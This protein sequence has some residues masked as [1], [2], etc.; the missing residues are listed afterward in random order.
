MRRFIAATTMMVMLLS[1]SSAL[2]DPH[3]GFVDLTL[4]GAG[5]DTVTAQY[6]P[7]VTENG[8][9][10]GPY[11][12]KLAA[13]STP[14][15]SPPTGQVSG[16]QP[17]QTSDLGTGASRLGFCISLQ[18][19]ISQNVLYKDFYVETIADAL[20]TVKAQNVTSLLY[21]Y[22]GAPGFGTLPPTAG[23]NKYQDALTMAIWE[24]LT[25]TSVTTP[26]GVTTGNVQFSNPSSGNA[27]SALAIADGWLAALPT[28]TGPQRAT[29]TSN[30][31]IYGLVDGNVQA[32]SIFI[33]LPGASVPEPGRVV[34]LAGM[35]LLG[36]PLGF[37][38][39]RRRYRH[40]AGAR[41]AT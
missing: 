24:V 18:N 41:R 33:S 10:L 32:Q 12:Y 1:A 13:A 15:P 4:T 29:I 37:I 34:G 40:S 20:G 38:S 2:A 26:F 35:G 19:S 31:G 6:P 14:L 3:L 21:L 7:S 39:L 16:M 17:V 9:L 30:T 11:A 36:L 27:A 23:S 28:V 5:P 25:E 22:E 8:V